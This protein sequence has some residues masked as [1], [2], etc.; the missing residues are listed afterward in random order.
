M[1]DT[2]T[3][4]TIAQKIINVLQAALPEDNYAFFELGNWLTD[5]SQLR[6]P[7]AHVGAK[8]TIATAAVEASFALKLPYVYSY[9]GM[10]PFL[11]EL[12]GTPVREGALAT[13]LRNLAF[14]VGCEK[15]TKLGIALQEFTDIYDSY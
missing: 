9:V 11:D 6:D 15:F 7:P 10:R 4:A 5:I 13:W 2:Y 8:K 3:H 14:I 12:M 1:G